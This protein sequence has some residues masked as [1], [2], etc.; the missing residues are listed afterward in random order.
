MDEK[1]LRELVERLHLVGAVRC[2]VATLNRR[3]SAIRAQG[4][5]CSRVGFSF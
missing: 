1:E 2:R 4:E 5:G 3:T